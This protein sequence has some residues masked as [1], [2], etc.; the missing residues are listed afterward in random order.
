MVKKILICDP[1]DE[2]A[3]ELLNSQ[4]GLDIVNQP[5]ISLEELQSV[6][7]N[8]DAVFIRSRTKL[9]EETLE[10]ATNLKVI[11][12][13]GTGL[14]NVDVA[15]AESKGIQVLN[16]P[17]A[18]ANAVAELTLGLMLMLARRVMQGIETINAGE[19]KKVKGIELEG[20]ML[21]LVGFG[22][23]GR[24]VA[25]L[26]KGFKMD[27]IAYDPL[28]DHDQI[29]EPLRVVPLCS[30]DELI[31]QSDFISL[32]VPFMDST[33]HLMNAERL[34]CMKKGSFLL[35]TARAGLT[36]DVAVLQALDSG[37]L[38][39]YATDLHEEDNPLFAHPNVIVTP[40]IGASTLESQRRA[41]EGIVRRVVEALNAL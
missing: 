16:T 7:A 21:G 15:F 20:K 27:V 11:G 25:R 10:K 22:N 5:D 30:L 4:D 14:D 1:M 12:R 23:I 39:G 8:Y 29:P 9:R 38:G 19:P 2:A 41:G 6:I 24:L 35:N 40:H 32:H 3:F 26:A 37:Q 28:I 33:K 13:A 31:P 17:G 36:D 34:T 18:N